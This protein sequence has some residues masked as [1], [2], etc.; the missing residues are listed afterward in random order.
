MKRVPTNVPDRREVGNRSFTSRRVVS[1]PGILIR[2]Q[3][4][5]LEVCRKEETKWGSGGRE[6]ES[7]SPDWINR[8][9]HS[10]TVGL[11]LRRF[12]PAATLGR[13][14]SVT[15][16]D[17]GPVVFDPVRATVVPVRHVCDAF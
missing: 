4:V 8:C 3:A 7:R 2:Y 5:R 13:Y 10:T 9:K 11:G 6:F 17:T 15:I 16:L 14:F 12:G 1:L